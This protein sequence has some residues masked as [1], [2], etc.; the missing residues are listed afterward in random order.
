MNRSLGGMDL[1]SPPKKGN[2]KGEFGVGRSK[3]AQR[4]QVNAKESIPKKGPQKGPNE[5]HCWPEQPSFPGV[6]MFPRKKDLQ[7]RR[8]RV[9]FSPGLLSCEVL[10]LRPPNARPLG[11]G[12]L[13]P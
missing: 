5:A 6:E 10:E 13:T 8:S 4:A 11:S 3:V 7:R 12:G 2:H 1:G 9:L